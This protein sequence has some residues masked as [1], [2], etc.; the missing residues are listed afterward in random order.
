MPQT[1][2]DRHRWTPALR[3]AVVALASDFF[4]WPLAERECFAAHLSCADRGK[5]DRVLLAELFGITAATDHEVEA[6][7]DE[8][9][10]EQCNVLN[11]ALQP[12]FGIGDDGFSL[13]EHFAE[14]DSLLNYETVGDW[15]RADFDFQERA[16]SE[17]DPEY[18]GRPYLG[19]LYGGWARL[20]VEDRFTYATLWMAAAHVHAQVESYAEGLIDRLIPHRYVPGSE[21]GKPVSGGYQWDMRTDAAG[22]EA[23]LD[24]LRRRWYAYLG[25]RHDVLALSWDEQ[26][27]GAVYLVERS[28]D[29]E[30]T[31]DVIFTDRTSLQAVRF[32]SFLDD[33]RHLE[34]PASE[35]EPRVEEEKAAAEVF[36]RAE[37]EDIEANF[38]PTVVPL[39][40]QRKVV[41]APQAADFLFPR[42]ED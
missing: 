26:R 33:C 1:P 19:N 2:P 11:A 42:D 8:L 41:I 39:R 10:L 29:G 7:I 37:L 15:D 18:A 20:F 34:R 25:E 9:D 31:V 4:A 32:R 35:L 38:D 13:T 6:A 12:L 30:H 28:E 40:K 21:H 3:R 22:R 36:L 14:G 23:A 17:E 5:L 16:R 24:E 27:P